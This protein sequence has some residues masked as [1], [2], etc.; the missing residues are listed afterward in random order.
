M[1]KKIIIILTACV[2][3]ISGICQS[4]SRLLGNWEGKIRVGTEV[5]V[6]FHFVKDSSGNISATTDSPDQGVKAIPC[7]DVSVQ[8]DSIFLKVPSANGSYSGLI[9]DSVSIR[10]KLKQGISFEL[11][12]KKVDKV[13]GLNRPQNPQPPFPYISE[14]IEYDNGA[15]TLHYGATI[16]IPHGKGPFP[17]VLL[18]T[19]SG[20]QNRD[21]E[22]M[23]HK[24]FAVLADYLTRK[25]IIVLRVDDRGV[26]KSTGDFSKSTTADFAIDAEN[27]LNFLKSR[28]EVD[29]KKIGLMGHSEGG[30]IAPMLAAKRK[31]IDF[32]ILL[33]GPGEK[34]SKLVEDQNAA[35]YRSAGINEKAIQSF[36]P[37]FQKMVV[38]INESNDVSTLDKKLE[39][40]LNE[41]RKNTE[42]AYVLATTRIYNDSSQKLF[43][44]TINGTLFTPWFKYFLQFDPQVYLRQLHCK[45][46]ALNGEKDLQVASKPNLAG[47]KESLQKAGTKKYDI[48][49][50]PQLNHLFQTCKTCTIMEYGQ[51]EET[52]SPV[53]LNLVGD[54]IEKNIK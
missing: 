11:N 25:G 41:W 3:A 17:A 19:G 10:G 53:A 33:A 16:T 15:K 37:F 39:S 50:V 4:D 42:P 52:F 13:A 26:G 51:L 27:S 36:R 12:L 32:I 40:S 38:L 23:E 47:I 21:E 45:V 9:T 6:V 22:I 30:M 49:E 28:P 7:S 18:I 24:P 31:D 14:D 1:L 34:I 48:V 44:E 2:P 43:I 46:L 54:W 35:L 20:P 29:Q 5:R 8:G